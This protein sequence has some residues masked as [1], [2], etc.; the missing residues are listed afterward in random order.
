MKRRYFH[1]NVRFWQEQNKTKSESLPSQNRSNEKSV[2]MNKILEMFRGRSKAYIIVLVV[3]AIIV[4]LTLYWLVKEP[5][6]EPLLSLLVLG[7]IFSV[8]GSLKDVSD[9]IAVSKKDIEAAQVRVEQNPDKAKP[10]WDLATVKLEAYLSANLKQINWIFSLSV[11]VMIMGFVFLTTAIFLTL[12]N[13]NFITPAIVAGV[14]GAVTE[15]IGATFL[16]L[17]R[18]ALEHSTNFIKSLDK[19]SSVGVAM[20]ILDNISTDKDETVREKIIDAKIE[21]AKL[22]LSNLSEK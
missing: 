13:P 7:A 15:F 19:T 2:S 21:V 4:I 3:L 18:S 16:V 20:Q 14:G 6:F 11:V 1:M 17:Y 22:L 10:A 9:I 8:L 5:G 12:Q